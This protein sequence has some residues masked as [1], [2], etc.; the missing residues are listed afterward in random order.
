[1]EI[2]EFSKYEIATY[3]RD[4]KRTMTY[5]LLNQEVPLYKVFDFHMRTDG[6]MQYANSDYYFEMISIYE[7]LLLSKFLT[8]LY[9]NHFEYL[10]EANV[11][12]LK[13]PDSIF[14]NKN[15]RSKF[16]SNKKIIEWIRNAFNHNDNPNHDLVRFIR[17]NENEEEK[18]KIEIFLKNTKPIPFHVLLD[19]DD[20]FSICFEIANPSSIIVDS[21]RSI[22]PIFLTSYNVNE[23][24]NNV[25]LRKF[26]AR[27]KLTEEQKESIISHVNKNGT[28]NNES[29]LLNNGMVYKDFHYT[30]EQIVKIKEDLKYW[31]SMGVHGNDVISHLLNKVM[32][33]SW[34]KERALRMNLVFADCYMKKG[35]K[36]IF[37]LVIDARKLI[38][39][40]KTSE[41]TPLSFYTNQYGIDN[42]LLYDALDFENLL[43]IT[44][45]IYFGY[46]FDSLVTDDEIKIN[47]TRTI[48]RKR[49][50]NSFVHM[51]WFKGI[52]E[53]FKLF[54]WG[55][56]IDN[57]YN[58]S[59]K[60]FWKANIQY[61]DMENC[62]EAYFKSNIMKM[63]K[64]ERYM[65]LP[66]HFKSYDS[67]AVEV[68]FIKN[69]VLYCYDLEE[70]K[71]QIC[72]E[73]QIQRD[74]D[75]SEIQI[76]LNELDNLT[77][78][79]KVEYEKEINNIKKT[80]SL[81]ENNNTNR[82]NH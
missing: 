79:E 3:L 35:T 8:F 18:I 17:V 28:K 2:Y 29:V 14:I 7:I 21:G 23:T 25:F 56:G 64:S 62:A 63:N 51:R 67:I 65:D 73:D 39:D 9:D 72:G 15:D 20:L 58:R 46:L 69:R 22:K 52:N 13:I 4:Y 26:Y 61:S 32:P 36:P 16:S 12:K 11:D 42:E 48:Q 76:F 38:L 6:R 75:N 10:L 81:E 53:C 50:R 5:A 68:S 27:K 37:D 71:L 41:D 74:A 54:D 43:S 33:F 55:N 49:I 19:I 40:K 34:K 70:N 45:S 30:I 77:N 31:E 44:D 59:S 78:K 57:E 47:D 24:I 1:M 66:I 60:S 82:T 80:L